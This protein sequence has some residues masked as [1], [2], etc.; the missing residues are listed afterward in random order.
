LLFALVLRLLSTAGLNGGMIRSMKINMLDIKGFGKLKNLKIYPFKGFNIIFEDNESGKSTLQ[1]FIKAMLYGLKGGR[2]APDGSLPPLKHFKPWHDSLYAG[3][4]EYSLDNSGTYLVKRNFEKGTV[5]IYRDSAFDI[6][7]EF[8]YERETG[9]KFA[10]QHLGLDELTFEK[11]VFMGQLQCAIDQKGRK[12]LV[13][14]LSN[15]NT[16]GDEEL[17][18]TRTVNVLET[19]LLERVGTERTTTRPLDKVNTKLSELKK[20]M[21]EL[22]ELNESY[23]DTALL[24]KQK[25]EEI[26]SLEKTLEQKIKHKENLK[27]RELK[28]LKSRIGSLKKEDGNIDSSLKELNESLEELKSFKDISDESLSSALF[29]LHDEARIKESMENAKIR[30]KELEENRK[31]LGKTLDDDQLFNM[32]TKNVEECIKNYTPAYESSFHLKSGS[33]ARRTIGSQSANNNGKPI[34][35]KTLI[36][37]LGFLGLVLTGTLVQEPSPVLVLVLV[38]LGIFIAA[39][40]ILT[41]M[42]G[43]RG[44]NSAN[45]HIS[46]LNK[47]LSD[48][49][50]S[51]MTSYIKYREQQL[52]GKNLLIQT[53]DK[54][55]GIKDTI[56]ELEQKTL[57]NRDKWALLT[58]ISGYF[59]ELGAIDTDK[60][61]DIL[62][63]NVAAVRKIKDRI[64]SLVL[65]KTEIK[66][67]IEILLREAENIAQ[68][69]IK[70]IQDIEAAVLRLCPEQD[71]DIPV[72]SLSGLD[73]EIDSLE[74]E[75]DRTRLEIA[76]LEARM[77]QVPDEGEA[78]RLTEEII[79]LE[80]EKKRLE[81]IGEGLLLAIRILNDVSNKLQ[82]NYIPALNQEMS[83]IM[84]KI[85]NGRYNRISTDVQQQI[86]LE[87]PEIHD[88]VSVNNLS[89]GTIDQL[90]FAMRLAAIKLM[91][92]NGETLPLFL[93][94]PFAQYDETRV[95]ECFEILKEMSEDHQ[96]FFFTCRKREYELARA[97]FNRGLN[98]I[99]IN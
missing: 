91:E 69:P 32:K 60:A 86:N 55:L 67:K 89:R 97:V 57:E 15:I 16:T 4:M 35:V 85:T 33:E 90:Y 27:I 23:L 73:S 26:I 19:T 36:L 84:S 47:A 6:T 9:P 22:D 20:Q 25:K 56:I 53:E 12:S 1:A 68:R 43:I 59:G 70:S 46:M 74:D 66:G 49:G 92:K 78:A 52:K 76:A 31:E 34:W 41:S 63:D 81:K 65:R 62:K 54:I 3:D 80:N 72:S 71:N 30:L 48:A 51:D 29:L 64:N 24:L 58:D 75:I 8:S 95:L 21:R 82:Y 77:E 79:R 87:S 10:E 17:S 99:C 44:A 50:F 42:K 14:K 40:F 38:L 5:S 98:R 61:A 11:T 94:E 45:S 2:K 18:L 93:D 39:I 37:I 28:D 13:E 83:I 96:I 88:F 7:S